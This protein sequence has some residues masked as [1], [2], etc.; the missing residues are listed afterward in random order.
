MMQGET[1]PALASS[2]RRSASCRAPSAGSTVPPSW[3]T[4][5]P[6]WVVDDLSHEG[7]FYTVRLTARPSRRRDPESLLRPVSAL[8]DGARDLQAEPELPPFYSEATVSRLL[9]VAEPK[10][11]I[12][13]VFSRP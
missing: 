6:R 5:R 7:L 4:E 10:D 12:R 8:V 3:S 2:R 9:K 1:R 13:E 11:G